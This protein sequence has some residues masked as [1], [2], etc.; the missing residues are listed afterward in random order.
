MAELTE[1][2]VAYAEKDSN[3]DSTATTEAGAQTIVT[4]AEITANGVTP[5]IIEVRYCAFGVSTTTPICRITL[6][7]NGAPI[8]TLWSEKDFLGV[9]S[10]RTGATLK[11]RLTPTAGG[12]IYSVRHWLSSAG[13]FRVAGAP[14]GPSAD[15]AFGIRVLSLVA[16]S[17]VGSSR[18]ARSTR[19]RRRAA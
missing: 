10:S 4:A 11:Y 6:F 1:I 12:H 13:T 8:G 7:D 18:A 3:T 5:Y 9:T 2:F 17:S 15:I 16:P 19:R 14:P